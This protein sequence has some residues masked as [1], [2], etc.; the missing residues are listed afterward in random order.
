[1][2]QKRGKKIQYNKNKKR[3]TTLANKKA[4]QKS[5][6][7]AKRQAKRLKKKRSISM[8]LLR[9][10]FILG[11]W[12]IV[13][14]SGALLWFAHDLPDI[15]RSA[16]F[17]HRPSI[18]LLAS[19]GTE[20]ARYGES[21]GQ[22][23]RIEDIPPYLTQAVIS[24]EDRRF[25]SHPGID[26]LGIA[27]AMVVNITHRRFVQGGSTI[28]Q[29]LAKNLFLSH[30]RKLTR[31][32]REAMLAI[33]LERELTKNEILSAYMNRV[34][35]GSG[36]YGFEAAAQLYF[37]KSAK[38][39]TLREAAVLAG[40]LKAPSKYSPHNN[41]EL[42]IKRSN[43][44]L[45]SMVEAG[46]IEKSDIQN[47]GIVMSLPNKQNNDRRTARYFA[48]WLINELD[49][50]VGSPDIDMVVHTTLDLSVHHKAEQALT[51]TIDNTDEM[52]FVSQGAVLVMQPDGAITTMIGGYSY[53][54]SQF[55][56]STQSRRPPGSAFKPIVYLTALERS[57]NQDSEILDAPI[58]EGQYRP[59]NFANKYYGS[60][61]LKTALA[62]SMN[63]ATVRLCNEV[64]IGHVMRT[65][66]DLGVSS[67]LQRNLSL[68]LGSSG[69]SMLEI[70]NVYTNFANGGY[71]IAPYGITSV[72]TPNGRLLYQRKAPNRYIRTID[73]SA[74]KA[75][76]HM[77]REVVETGTGRAAAQNFPVYG[78]TG[79]SQD[80]RDAWFA[81]YSKEATA[82]IWLGNDD[83]SPMRH[84]TGGGLPARIFAKVIAAAHNSNAPITYPSKQHDN[85]N[86]NIADNSFSNLLGKLLSAG[87]TIAPDKK[88]IKGDYS[89]LN[90]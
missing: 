80:Y 73:H 87:K 6:I 75:L 52:Q 88:N 86:D 7:K 89:N 26:I 16:T 33:W 8:I 40:L 54:Q 15:T 60:V 64:G 67:D 35:L 84:I 31:K 59:K 2:T 63:T 21:K 17:E 10:G 56:R 19:D 55:N 28:T 48:D 65:A 82:I 30:E 53:N 5:S 11:I 44:V 62:K 70:A 46:Y 23:I 78:K 49:K 29:Q 85:N 42:A 81:G 72:H 43:L 3:S 68:C 77:L 58:T 36:T 41:P 24:T 9:W 22:N 71:N 90:E 4:A 37:G 27:R 66:Y 50:V 13:F 45:N 83:N 25:Y 18:I 14:I 61:S 34:Y 32:I 79:T 74:L 51:N 20:F 47:E 1:M 69:I 12:G 38:N 76:S 57:W 39:V